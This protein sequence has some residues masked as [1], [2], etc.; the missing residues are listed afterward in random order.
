MK[1]VG[2]ALGGLVKHV[3]VSVVGA[4]EASGPAVFQAAG[5]LPLQGEQC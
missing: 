2:K 4:D 1:F 3:L 5:L